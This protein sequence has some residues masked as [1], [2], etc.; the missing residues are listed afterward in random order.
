MTPD[1]FSNKT[2]YNEMHLKSNGEQKSSTALREA[3]EEVWF[4]FLPI[5]APLLRGTKKF[6]SWNKCLMK[7][8]YKIMT[9]LEK[10]FDSSDNY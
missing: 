10:L 5:L 1:S 9:I 6:L 2:G 7:E 4:F 3:Y 8:F